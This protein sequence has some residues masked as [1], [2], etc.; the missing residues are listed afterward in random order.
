MKLYELTQAVNACI[1]Y[2][3]EHVVNTEDGEIMNL[4]K[5][6]ELVMERNAKIEA[7]AC[8]IKNTLAS[9]EAIDNEIDNLKARA[10]ALKKEAER[11]KAYLG[12]ELYGEKFESPRCKIT[13]RKSEVCNILNIEEV[14]EDYKRTKL[15]IDPNKIAIKEAIKS[16][17]DVPGA[18]ILEKLNMTLR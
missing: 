13:W 15:V 6:T 5:F 12:G 3:A 4:E 14:P 1:E 11:C 7:L 2:D 9:A 10:V 17:I 18:E 16:G 8:Y